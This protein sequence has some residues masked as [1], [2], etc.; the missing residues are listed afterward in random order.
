MSAKYIISNTIKGPGIINQ[1]FLHPHNEGSETS[2]ECEYQTTVLSQ[3]ASVKEN[4]GGNN[5]L[6][7]C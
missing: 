5:I 6:Q 3:W 7:K 1:I 2:F 4:S